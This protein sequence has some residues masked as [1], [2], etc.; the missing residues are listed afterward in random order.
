ML[1]SIVVLVPFSATTFLLYKYIYNHN[2]IQTYSHRLHVPKAEINDFIAAK[3]V[4][5]HHLEILPVNVEDN[6]DEF[7]PDRKLHNSELY[8]KPS[9]TLLAEKRYN[10]LIGLIFS[11]T[12]SLSMLLMLLILCELVDYLSEET[13]LFYI[14]C[15]IN[16]LVFLLTIAQPFLIVSL[17]INNTVVPVFKSNVLK[18]V[19]T[20]ALFLCWLFAL[21]KCGDL[22]RTFTPRTVSTT[23]SYNQNTKTI[24]ENKINEI[25][26]A[27]IT[28]LAVLSGIGST[29][30]PYK[31]FAWQKLISRIRGNNTS[32]PDKNIKPTVS[33]EVTE[34]DINAAIRY[35]NNTCSLLTRRA[36]DLERL[37]QSNSGTIYNLPSNDSVDNMLKFNG[38]QHS[39]PSSPLKKRGFGGLL[40]K[41]QSFASLNAAESLEQ[42][43]LSREINSL[44]IL[45]KSL[46][47]DVIKQISLYLEQQQR[48]AAR[49]EDILNI[50]LKWGNLAFGVYCVYRIANVIVI[51]IPM[52]I[53]YRHS[54]GDEYELH[55]EKTNVISE[56][57][58]E[59]TAPSASKD[60]LATTLS[61]MILFIFHTLPVTES[62]LIN[63]FSF[64]LSGSLFVCSFSNVLMTFKSFGRFLPASVGT[65]LS[66]NW[67]KHLIISELL[68]VYVI[69]TALL[70]R[71]N[72]P[73]NLS[74]QVSKIL[75][76]SGSAIRNPTF[77]MKEVEFIDNWFDKVFAISCIFTALLIAV[78]KE[79]D[80]NAWIHD[81]EN[82]DEELFIE[83]DIYKAA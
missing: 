1:E 73:T 24:I 20:M 76:L 30:T 79:L 14:T 37:V 7:E 21:H 42:S 56:Q 4:R 9:S 54:T 3:L 81:L 49:N 18:F 83:S 43:E 45:K 44:K 5:S 58:P 47:D 10:M 68:G 51:R 29:S 75:S 27:G 78:R 28:I 36:A 66:K 80:R 26:I 6:E 34:S 77:A 64:V 50:L 39:V 15:T 35:Y 38:A 22:S 52:M 67:L 82:Y 74:Q 17:F 48:L 8:N 13:R 63:L 62:Q 16:S 11:I 2:L 69:A 70:I 19:Q 65:N 61:K 55:D 53:L 72:L 41:V 59:P 25:S 40:H 31:L 71:T 12:I 23:S 33:R 60:A 32:K 57:T 46:Y